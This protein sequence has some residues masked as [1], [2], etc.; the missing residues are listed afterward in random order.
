MYIVSTQ[1]LRVGA[2]MNALLYLNANNY[3]YVLI[4]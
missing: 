1:L 3:V 4:S 2:E